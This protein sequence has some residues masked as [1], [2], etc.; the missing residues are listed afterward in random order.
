MTLRSGTSL[1]VVSDQR[2]SNGIRGL[3]GEKQL[4]RRLRCSGLAALRS[5][6]GLPSD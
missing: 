3:G 6:V 2:V 5:A 4:P 1:S